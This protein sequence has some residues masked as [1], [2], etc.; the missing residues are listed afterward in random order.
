MKLWVTNPLFPERLTV[1][2][3]LVEDQGRLQLQVGG[4]PVGALEAQALGLS[5][6]AGDSQDRAR[7]A[8]WEQQN[9]ELCGGA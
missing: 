1:E 5:V 8:A 4:Q 7:W 2:A 3:V 9:Q 6:F